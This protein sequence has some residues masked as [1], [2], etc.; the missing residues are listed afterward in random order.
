VGK[1]DSHMIKCWPI[2]LLFTAGLF[3][4]EAFADCIPS[5]DTPASV[6][7]Y[8]QKFNKPL[9]ER[10]CTKEDSAPQAS[11]EP[12]QE[13][14]QAYEDAAPQGSEE[15]SQEPPQAYEDAPPPLEHRGDYT[16]FPPEHRGDY[17]RLPPEY[18]PIPEPRYPPPYG[19]WSRLAFEW[20][21]SEL[22][23]W[24]HHKKHKNKHNKQNEHNKHKHHHND[25]D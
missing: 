4:G 8:F 12:S 22:D 9:P 6:I 15:P 17:P 20:L 14:A 21:H 10:F 7:E 3:G 19:V 16:W 11:E 2:A 1:F 13:P 24:Y 23:D 5:P 25:N 18:L